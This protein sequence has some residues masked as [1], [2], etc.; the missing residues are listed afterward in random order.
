MI[1][2]DDICVALTI[3]LYPCGVYVCG[4]C[5]IQ[6]EESIVPFILYV[7]HELLSEY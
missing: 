2:V 6:V 4:T 5:F 3:R 7:A 1:R